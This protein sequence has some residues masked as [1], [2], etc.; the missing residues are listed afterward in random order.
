[1]PRYRN[2]PSLSVQI[3]EYIHFETSD[4]IS[5]QTGINRTVLLTFV[6]FLCTNNT[7]APGLYTFYF[8]GFIDFFGQ[9]V[10]T[11][12]RVTYEK[13]ACLTYFTANGNEICVM[14]L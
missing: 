4:S 3:V 14:C 7:S 13:P 8:E 10:K 9:L 5:L 2:K 1:M 6:N 12:W 11:F